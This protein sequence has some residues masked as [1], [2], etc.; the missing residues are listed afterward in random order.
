MTIEEL[1]EYFNTVSLPNDIQLTID[2]HIFDLPQFLKANLA[3][4]ER[5]KRDVEKCPSY[6]R[7]INLKKALE[8]Q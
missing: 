3:A 6:L 7:L 8:S 2:M 4:L 5:W 1:N